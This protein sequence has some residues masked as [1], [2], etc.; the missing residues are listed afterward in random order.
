MMTSTPSKT[1]VDSLDAQHARAPA[2]RPARSSGWLV[3]P[4]RWWI[5][6]LIGRLREGSLSLVLPDGQCVEACGPIAGVHASIVL[7]R[8]RALVRLMF[9]GD[10]GLARAY[11]DGDWS[12]PDL[13]ALLQLGARNEVHWA[14]AADGSWPMRAVHRIGHHLRSNTRRGSRDNISFHYDLGNE[15]YA[16]WLDP[17]LVYS[18]ALYARGDESLET[19]QAEKTS[20]IL[21]LLQL[22]D[23][24]SVLEIGCGWGA[25]AMTLARSRRVQVTG[26]TLSTAQFEHARQRAAREGLASRIDLRLQDY[27]DVAGRYDRI[28]SIEMLEA[29]GEKFWPVYFDTL[30][31]RLEDDGTAVLQVITMADAFFDRYR[32]R[33]DFVQRFIFP[34]GMLP[35]WPVLQAQA[36]RAGMTIERAVSF[37]ESYAATLVHWRERFLDAWPAIESLGFGASF[38]RLWEYYLCYCEAGFR[39]GR[40]EVGLYVVRH[41][42]ASEDAARR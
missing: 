37:G 4:L 38:R 30:R 13:V 27:R 5:A 34:G 16:L 6:R 21:E 3:R 28:V 23:G 36:Q 12:C 17:E 11:R 25:L 41:V 33:A 22:E 32:E 29:V 39:C 7:N 9:Q 15:F 40:V 18:S 42:G 2:C 19:A 14:A 24:A 26:L 31:Q 20:R 1:S 8:W 10:I 35:S